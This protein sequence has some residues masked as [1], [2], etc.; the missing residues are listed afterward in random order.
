[1]KV[2]DNT[3]PRILLI[4]DEPH[5]LRLLEATLLVDRTPKYMTFTAGDGDEGLEFNRSFQA[6]V[7]ITDILMP[8]VDG[9]AVLRETKRLYPETEV[10]M[11]S[12][13]G[14]LDRAVEA[15][16]LGAFDYLTKPVDGSKIRIAARNAT[17]SNQLKIHTKD[18]EARTWDGINHHAG[19]AFAPVI[20]FLEILEGRVKELEP[21]LQKEL[22][23]LIKPLNIGF[24]DGYK[25]FKDYQRTLPGARNDQIQ[26]NVYENVAFAIKQDNPRIP[27]RPMEESCDKEAKVFAD[28]LLLQTSVEWIL[29]DLQIV[30]TENFRYTIFR[31]DG[32]V[33]INIGYNFTG[34]DRPQSVRN[35]GLGLYIADK[36]VGK[37]GGRLLLTQDR[38]GESLTIKLPEYKAA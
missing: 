17:A 27:K 22:M 31:D 37:M 24:Y 16:K 32:N 3:P 8:R 1:M 30:G 35:T 23:E 5:M 6:G 33:N 10:V 25:V 21:Q 12:G 9:I 26:S 29:R 34:K 15:V 18:L 28:P 4:D 13:Q 19:N 14:S 38:F 7:I 2:I 36:L 20:A 11:V